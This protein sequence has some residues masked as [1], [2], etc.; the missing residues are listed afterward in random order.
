[1]IYKQQNTDGTP[2]SNEYDNFLRAKS[3]SQIYRYSYPISDNDS[4]N[5]LALYL[6]SGKSTSNIIIPKLQELGVDI[7]L[8]I[9]SDTEEIWLFKEDQIHIVNEVMHFQI[10]GRNE[11]LKQKIREDKLRLKEEKLRLQEEKI[12][13]KKVKNN[14]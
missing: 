5:L 6:P 8:F 2:S 9:E 4:E 7:N 14:K 1:M 13:S 11:Q 3:N 12:K 10:K